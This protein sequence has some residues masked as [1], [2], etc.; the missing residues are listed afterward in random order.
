MAVQVQ[1]P[2]GI[3]EPTEVALDRRH[4]AIANPEIVVDGHAIGCHLMVAWVGIQL[5]DA[6]FR[7]APCGRLDHAHIIVAGLLLRPGESF[8]VRRI[9]F[10]NNDFTVGATCLSQTPECP[11]PWRAHLHHDVAV[12]DREFGWQRILEI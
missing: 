2:Q 10:K 6:A 3:V 11:W 8:E 12:V 7:L 4:V 9:D 1:L 5:Q